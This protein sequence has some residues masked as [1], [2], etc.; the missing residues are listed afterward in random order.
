MG[1]IPIVHKFGNQVSPITGL[2]RRVTRAKLFGPPRSL[3]GSRDDRYKVQNTRDLFKRHSDELSGDGDN[4][5]FTKQSARAF[6]VPISVPYTTAASEFLYGYSVVL[7][8]LRA[9]RRKLYNL[10]LH[11]R[12]RR[13]DGSN[14]LQQWAGRS[15]VQ[16]HDVGDEW[17]PIMDKLSSGR[18][19]NGCILECSPL[20]RPPVKALAQSSVVGSKNGIYGN[21]N[22]RLNPQSGEDLAVNGQNELYQ[23]KSNG[24]RHPLVLYVDGVLDEGNL[25]ALVRSAYFLG[26]DAIATPT[27]MSAPLSQIALKAS[28]GAAEAIPIFAISNPTE[29]LTESV[30]F[31]WQVY[32]SDAPPPVSTRSKSVVASAIASNLDDDSSSIIFTMAGSNRPL[33]GHTPLAKHP[34]ILMLGSEGSG[35]RS[36]LMARAHYKVG[37][38]AAREVDEIG[39]DSLNVSAAS[40]LLC[41]EFMKRP[42]GLVKG[43]FLF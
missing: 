4:T 8:A 31:G 24:W 12:S 35:L 33:Y 17:L 5:G 40:A 29:F 10:Y 21:Y 18:P 1:D 32:A 7:A 9:N 16:V 42:K 38:R 2:P 36:S 26:V 3:E 22:I 6:T 30:V 27:R 25:G 39:V 19:H 11:S 28:S 15:N 37:I 34:T 43:D 14:F 23:Y 41:F 13:N 20:P